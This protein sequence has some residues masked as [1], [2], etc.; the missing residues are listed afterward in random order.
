MCGVWF[1]NVPLFLTDVRVCGGS[2]YVFV[3]DPCGCV[4]VCVRV[5]LLMCACV[6][7][8]GEGEGGEEEVEWEPLQVLQPGCPTGEGM[9]E[10]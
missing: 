8:P 5:C 9:E 1:L 7:D 4:C 2:M 10:D 6:W 3:S